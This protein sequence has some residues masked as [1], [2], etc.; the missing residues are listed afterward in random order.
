MRAVSIP[1]ILLDPTDLA[2]LRAGKLITVPVPPMPH[3]GRLPIALDG[4]EGAPPHAAARLGRARRQATKGK[5]RMSTKG[6]KALAANLVKAR[7][8]KAAKAAAA[9]APAAPR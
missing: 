3:G 9:K 6:R 1:T 4:V 7:K 5:R 2:L 8:A